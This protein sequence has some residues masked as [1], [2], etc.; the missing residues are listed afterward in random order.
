MAI[1]QHQAARRDKRPGAVSHITFP[2]DFDA[3]V[4]DVFDP[5]GIGRKFQFPLKHLAGN[6]LNRPK[7]LAALQMRGGLRM[8]VVSKKRDFAN[9]REN[10]EFTCEMRIPRDT[11]DVHALHFLSRKLVRAQYK[12]LSQWFSS[13]F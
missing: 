6:I 11:M 10:M 12:L 3:R 5:I 2:P 9:L 1:R 4:L 8:N 7:P 13:M